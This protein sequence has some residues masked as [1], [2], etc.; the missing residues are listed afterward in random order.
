[1]YL[2]KTDVYNS[3]KELPYSVSQTQPAIFTD[4][5]AIIFNVGNNGVSADLDGNIAN[6]DIE[7]QIDIWAED[8]VT[9]STILS[10][11]EEKMRSNFY[12]MSFSNDVPNVSNL[13]HIV[14]RFAKSV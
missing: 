11:V 10:Q 1:M 14:S 12:I 7:I 3:L 2:P 9:A 13:Y 8:S 6:Q 4:L 5:P